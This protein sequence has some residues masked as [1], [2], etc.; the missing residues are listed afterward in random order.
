MSEQTIDFKSKSLPQELIGIPEEDSNV[1]SNLLESYKEKYRA[2]I[3]PILAKPES[4]DARVRTLETRLH[5]VNR[6]RAEH[7]GRKYNPS[8]IL[9][10]DRIQ[11]VLQSDSIN[12]SLQEN[13]LGSFGRFD[14]NAATHFE[15]GNFIVVF[16]NNFEDRDIDAYDT[17][18]KLRH[19]MSHAG[20]VRKMRGYQVDDVRT[21]LERYRVGAQLSSMK[22]GVTLGLVVDEGHHAIEDL[23]FD[24]QH[25]EYRQVD[26]FLKEIPT[27]D[28]IIPNG[29][30]KY[31]ALR[32]KLVADGVVKATEMMMCYW[33]SEKIDMS[34]T[35]GL[36]SDYSGLME[37]I[38]A[39]DPDFFLAGSELVY[40]DKMLAFAKKVEQTYG[41]G[42]FNKLMSLQDRDDTKPLSEE[43]GKNAQTRA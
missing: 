20:S 31:N 19:E 27:S 39:G 10:V 9:Y 21:S 7:Y 34:G 3:E 35:A 29:R 14:A 38:Y 37:Q 8:E 40:A 11:A 43:I 13:G 42:Y 28:E 23:I 22:K 32:E 26:P 24:G 1:V 12:Q 4:V 16:V 41:K 5:E 6:K 18:K 17:A 33:K 25:P 36:Y 2:C 30:Q 15:I